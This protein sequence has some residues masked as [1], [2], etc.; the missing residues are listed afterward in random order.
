MNLY[1]KVAQCNY[2]MY[3]KLGGDVL[4]SYATPTDWELIGQG[5]VVR[6]D[7][8][9]TS[10]GGR[11][12]LPPG[13]FT[14]QIVEAGQKRSFYLAL[15]SCSDTWPLAVDPG[16]NL[17]EGVAAEDAHLILMEGIKK[18]GGYSPETGQWPGLSPAEPFGMESSCKFVYR[19]Y[20][21]MYL[22]L[23]NLSQRLFCFT[24]FNF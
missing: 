2:Q 9:P 19:L 6:N 12:K 11:T 23:L 16:N 13:G 24:N 20:H 3:T 14:P 15:L 10:L 8:I 7:T 1:F 22:S 4:T 21:S 5:I 18:V 17:S